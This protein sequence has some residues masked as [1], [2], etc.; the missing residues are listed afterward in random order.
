MVLISKFGIVL[1]RKRLIEKLL[2]LT[3]KITKPQHTEIP[4]SLTGKMT[5]PYKMCSSSEAELKFYILLWEL[6]IQIEL[7][8]TSISEDL[9]LISLIPMVLL[10]HIQYYNNLLICPSSNCS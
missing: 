2:F 1:G 9:D 6:L 10:N 8:S 3:R 7:V 5:D 4:A